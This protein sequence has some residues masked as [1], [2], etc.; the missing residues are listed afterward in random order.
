MALDAG[1]VGVGVAQGHDIGRGEGLC[2]AVAPRIVIGVVRIAPCSQELIGNQ[3]DWP[4]NAPTGDA[5]RTR[6]PISHMTKVMARTSVCVRS[7]LS[8]RVPVVAIAADSGIVVGSS[9][10]S[11]PAAVGAVCTSAHRPTFSWEKA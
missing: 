10:Q 11:G 7:S 1:P 9:Q 6:K 2:I 5:M 4:K 3:R 8:H